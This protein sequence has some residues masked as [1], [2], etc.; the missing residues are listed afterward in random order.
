MEDDV[1]SWMVLPVDC[2]HAVRGY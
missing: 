2:V 1:E